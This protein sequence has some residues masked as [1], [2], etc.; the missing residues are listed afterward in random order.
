MEGKTKSFTTNIKLKFV[1]CSI[2]GLFIFFVNVPFN[3]SSK[4]PMVHIMNTIQT[5][6]GPRVQYIFV[7][8]SCI[9]VLAASIYVRLG[10]N[11]PEILKETYRKDNGF[12]Y[13]SYAAAAIFSIMV[14]FNIGPAPILDPEIGES[15]LSVAADSFFAIMVAGTLVA[16]ITEFGFLEFLGK[17]LEP[18]MRRVYQVPGK[19]AVDAVSSFVAAPAAGVMITNDLYQKKVYT[20]REASSITTNFS[21][22][23]LGGFAF[24]SSIAGIEDLYN[25]VVLAAFICVFV[26]AAIMIR[27]PPLS[28]KP[29]TY[30]DGTLQT[31]EQR[32]PENYSRDTFPQACY[33]GL[34]KCSETKFSVFWE[35]LKSS[36][37]FGVKV[38][39]FIVSLS[40]IGL[41]L[42]NYTPI[43][44]WIAIPMAPILSLLGLADAETIAAS[45]VVGVF[46]LS[47]PATLIKGK[48]VAAA[49]AFFVVVLSTSQIIFFTESANAMLESDIPLGF[50]DLIKVFLLRT[51]ILIPMVALMAKILV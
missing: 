38:N 37:M 45:S 43:A 6:L 21:I 9:C 51:V 12:S 4:V 49:S 18:I 25:E 50:W 24:V 8:V 42:F 20:A 2:V 28:R 14:I 15:S 22:A 26:L 11:V 46:A 34:A 44:Q 17:L 33:D 31:E 30:I 35:Q 1:I 32:K 7:M 23:S 40:V 3:G 27:I 39:A 10:K 41:F 19:A 48:A 16:F 36:F 5:A 29:D 47:I 13:F